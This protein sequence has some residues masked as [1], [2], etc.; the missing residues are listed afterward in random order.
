MLQGGANVRHRDNE[1]RIISKE[2]YLEE[3]K[4]AQR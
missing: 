4:Y 3:D 1:S 2:K